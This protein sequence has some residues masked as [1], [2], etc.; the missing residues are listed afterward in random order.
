MWVKKDKLLI[1]DVC[2]IKRDDQWDK[3]FYTGKA[4]VSEALAS[5]ALLQKSELR[6]N[7][8]NDTESLRKTGI[9]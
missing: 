2:Y 7:F 3:M 8:M 1:G 5:P 6:K 9:R 4:W